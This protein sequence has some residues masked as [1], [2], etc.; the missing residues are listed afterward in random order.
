MLWMILSWLG[1]ESEK[2]DLTF[3]L[4]F[5][6]EPGSEYQELVR[7]VGET[8]K[9]NRCDEQESQRSGEV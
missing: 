1:K 5:V 8:D 3:H 6:G 4:E 9:R 7:F 2:R